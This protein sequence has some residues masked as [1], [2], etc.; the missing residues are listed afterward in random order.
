MSVFPAELRRDPFPTYEQLR[1]AAPVFHEPR[2]DAYLLLAHDAVKRALT[3]HEAFSS[4]AAAPGSTPAAWLIFQDPPR[5]ATLRALITRAFT[6]RAVAALEPRVRALSAQLLAPVRSRGEVDLTLE[7][8]VPLPIMVIADLLGAPGDDW[9][10][11]RRWSDAILGLGE[12]LAGGEAAT[13]AED[14]FAAVSDEMAGYLDGL[15]A[16]RRARPADDLLTR[17]VDAEVDGD[18]LTATELLGFFQLLLLAGH[19]TTT[20]LI[21]NA[22]I[23]LLDHPD[24]LAR[25]RAE[26]RLVTSAIEEVLRF[27]SPVQAVFRVARRDLTLGAHGVPAGALVL[28]V[29][30]AANRDPAVFTEPHRFDVARAPNPHLAFGHGIHFCIGA[31][32]ARLEAKVALTDLLAL[33]GLAHA[34]RE[35][36]E[37]RDAFHVHGPA[38]LPVR[39]TA[40]P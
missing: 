31:A 11:L 10:R 15:I 6:P 8:A 16:A 38:R 21:G 12:T 27:R 39:F 37:P 2:I 35:P 32:L 34:G 13:R 17:L 28:P 9:P 7:Y 23:C 1:A 29:I 19:E 5:H 14:A 18:R 3:D 24:A 22:V 40:A 4:A 36:W 33:A 25:L 30:G 20:N 26:P